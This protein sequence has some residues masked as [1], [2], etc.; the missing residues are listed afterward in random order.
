MIYYVINCKQHSDADKRE[1][2]HSKVQPI[3]RENVANKKLPILAPQSLTNY[4]NS[5][6]QN[7]LSCTYL[8]TQRI[9]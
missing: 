6:T 9:C 7:M 4:I 5:L 1:D 3:W 2:M 8:W